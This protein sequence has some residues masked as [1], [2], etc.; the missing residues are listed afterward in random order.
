MVLRHIERDRTMRRGSQGFVA[1]TG[2]RA[3]AALSLSTLPGRHI[4][5]SAGLDAKGRNGAV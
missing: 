2:P 4:G 3:F 5:Q 1:I